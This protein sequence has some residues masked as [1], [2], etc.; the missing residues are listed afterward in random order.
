MKQK[1]NAGIL[2]AFLMMFAF[3]ACKDAKK[4]EPEKTDTPVTPTAP[5]RDPAMDP[6]KVAPGIYHVLADTLDIRISE[7]T[8]KP[9]ESVAMHSHPDHSIYVAEGGTVE[10]EAKDGKKSTVELKTGTGVVVPAET[11]AGKNTGTTTLKLVVTEVFRAATALPRDPATDPVKIAP[12]VYKVFADTMNIRISEV[13]V[14]PG[15]SVA[16][17][18]HPDHSIYVAQGGTVE[19]ES[20]DGKKSTSEL[21][22]G[23][24]VVV[25]AETHAG[26]NTGTAPVK[27]I[28]TE[29]FRPGN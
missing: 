27:L 10:F 14:K 3:I 2:L 6:V 18:T 28:L 4:E 20:K 11:H 1:N 23:M 7:V 21:K 13:T 9:G 25:P 17:H 24:G 22:S 5:T 29:V 12:G 16:M 8:V 15:E 26:K 19:F